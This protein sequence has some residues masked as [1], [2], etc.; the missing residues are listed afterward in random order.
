M[1]HH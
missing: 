1:P